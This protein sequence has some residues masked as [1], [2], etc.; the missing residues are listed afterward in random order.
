MNG[1]SV[2]HES[3]VSIGNIACFH[4]PHPQIWRSFVSFHTE[5]GG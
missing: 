4:P 1:P 3:S 5:S 2:K